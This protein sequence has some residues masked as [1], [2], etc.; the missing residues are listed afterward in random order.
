MVVLEVVAWA[1]TQSFLSVTTRM[2]FEVQRV[3]HAREEKNC[4]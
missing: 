2:V 3:R 1:V 4:L